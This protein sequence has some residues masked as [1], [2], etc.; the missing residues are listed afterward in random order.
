[1]KIENDVNNLTLAQQTHAQKVLKDMI[2]AVEL[3]ESSYTY[4]CLDDENKALIKR[5]M[6]EFIEEE[7]PTDGA[8][9]EE[10]LAYFHTF[11][12]KIKAE[13]QKLNTI[14]NKYN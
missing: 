8:P 9:V 11:K 7:G 2:Y 10:S 3:I 4:F 14:I 5:L 12:M 6:V 1:M 13:Y